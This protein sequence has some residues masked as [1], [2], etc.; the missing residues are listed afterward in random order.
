MRDCTTTTTRKH[1]PL[2]T[3]APYEPTT[4][5]STCIPHWS[6]IPSAQA[7]PRNQANGTIDSDAAT[8][9]CPICFASAQAHHR[10]QQQQIRSCFL[11]EWAQR[12]F[13]DGQKLQPMAIAFSGCA[14]RDRTHPLGN[15]MAY[16]QLCMYKYIY[17]C[18][19]TKIIYIYLSLS[20]KT[21]YKYMSLSTLLTSPRKKKTE[22]IPAS[23]HRKTKGS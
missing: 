11:T 16:K 12:V 19:Y 7:P 23:G 22:T 2:P 21:F 15:L 9:I 20:S 4:A 10:G 5:H 1:T 17:I 18:I 14:R 3:Q 6:N 13:T 8:H